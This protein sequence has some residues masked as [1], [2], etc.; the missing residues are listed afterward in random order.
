M[1]FTKVKWMASFMLILPWSMT[2]LFTSMRICIMKI[3]HQRIFL[4]GI[5]FVSI[6]LDDAR[7]LEKDFVEDEV[8]NAISEL[9][10]EKALGP[11]G[12]NIAF[13]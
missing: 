13:F 7:D 4:G 10:N 8:W 1:L 11:D 2:R 6:S 12:F 5:T 3:N 9:G